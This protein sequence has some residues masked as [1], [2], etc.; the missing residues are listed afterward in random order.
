LKSESRT[1][2]LLRDVSAEQHTQ[3][4]RRQFVS[5]ASHELKSPVAG[6]QVLAEAIGQAALDDPESAR[7]FAGRLIG[8]TQRLA[9]LIG[10]LLDLSRLEAP[11]LLQRATIA[12]GAVARREAA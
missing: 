10:D 11:A 3:R 8:E 1:L 4:I 6:I 7:E 5:N 9:Q 2:V 12:L